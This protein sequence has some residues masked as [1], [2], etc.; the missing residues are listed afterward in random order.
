MKNKI[1]ILIAGIALFFATPSA[2]AQ[3][4]GGTV[5]G[6][7]KMQPQ[8]I[9]SGTVTAVAADTTK[10][11]D[12]SYAWFNSQYG[13]DLTMQVTN[14]VLTGTTAGVITYQ[15]SPDN[16]NWY[17]LISDSSQCKTCGYQLTVG[18]S[19]ITGCAQFPKCKF[20]YVRAQIITTGTQTSILT[21]KLWEWSQFVTN[22]N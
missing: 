15:G 21:G 12:T 17:S 1:A 8:A 5:R 7:V 2:Q 14:T 18:A 20:P 16:V 10:N 11:A 6:P 3:G 9:I 19:T 13:W 4:G 22:L